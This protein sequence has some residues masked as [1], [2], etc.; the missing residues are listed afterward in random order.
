MKIDIWEGDL[1]NGRSA[2][3]NWLLQNGTTELYDGTL[4]TGVARARVDLP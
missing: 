2:L 4:I 3:E 1:L